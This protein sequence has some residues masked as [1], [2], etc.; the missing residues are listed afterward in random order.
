MNKS[1]IHYSCGNSKTGKGI[2]IFNMKTGVTC[3]KEACKTC[4]LNGCYAK[5][6]DSRFKVIAQNDFSDYL[7]AKDHPD[8]LER[9]INS[10]VTLSSYEN[11]KIVRLHERGDFFSVEYLSNWLNVSDE[12]PDV[13]FWAYTKQWNSVR[14]NISK[15]KKKTNFT[16]YASKWPGINIPSDIADVLPI[17]YY[18]DIEEDV[19][20]NGVFV[21]KSDTIN[22]ATGKKFTCVECGLCMKSRKKMHVC[23]KA[24]GTKALSVQKRKLKLGV[25]AILNKK[26][27]AHELIERYAA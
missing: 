5:N 13:M 6:E 11:Y 7:L 2:L 9:C 1:V 10:I 23:F 27:W 8:I 22:P 19:P 21:C 26:Y 20:V 14:G 24:H 16:V 3:S 4:Y 17:A 12:F 25:T 15:L 18:G